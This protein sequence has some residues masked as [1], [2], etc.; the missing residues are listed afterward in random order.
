MLHT[1]FKYSNKLQQQLS[2][3]IREPQ[4]KSAKVIYLLKPLWIGRE[5]F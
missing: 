3:K 1:A 2:Q 5:K 4:N